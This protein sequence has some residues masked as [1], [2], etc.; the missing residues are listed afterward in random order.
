H[1]LIIDVVSWRIIVQDLQ[2]LLTPKALTGQLLD[3]KTSSYRQWVDTVKN[4][5]SNHQQEVVYWQNVMATQVS[6]PPVGKLS[7]QLVALSIKVTD[8]LLRQSNLGYHTQINDLLLS[9][10][11]VALKATFAQ[12]DNLI[13]LEG[14]GREAIDPSIDVSHTLGWFTTTYPVLLS[15]TDSISDTIIQTKEMLNKTPEK[16]IGFGA[17]LATELPPVSFNY[18]GQLSAGKDNNDNNGDWQIITQGCGVPI[19]PDNGDALLLNINGA[20]QQGQ[21]QFGVDSRLSSDLTARFATA[22]EAALKAVIEQGQ[23]QAKMGSI[24][25]PADFAVDISIEHLR[26]LQSQYPAPNAIEALYPANSLQQ[27]FI[28]HYLS[29]PKDDAYRVQMLIDYN[30]A[31]DVGL[32]QQAWSL[33]SLRYPAL[34][35]AFDWQ[36]Q[37]LQVF[38]TQSSISDDNFSV[39]DISDLPADQRDGAIEQIQGQDRARDF[40]LSQPGLIRFTLIKQHETLTTVLKTEHHGISDGWSWPVLMQCVH[41]FYDALS[42]GQLPTVEPETAYLAAQAFNLDDQDRINGYWT[43]EKSRFGEANDINRM[44]SRPIDL[45]TTKTVVNP[46]EQLLCLQGDTYQQLKA[47]CKDQGV[48]LNV[49]LQFAWHKLI[50]T[51]CADEQTIVGTTVSGRDLAV[52]GIESSVGLYINTLP[53]VVDW[54]EHK[55][56]GKMLN[57]IALQMASLN[58]YSNVSLASLQSKGERLFHSLLVFENYPNP[59]AENGANH[60]IADDITLRYSVEKADYPLTLTAYEQGECLYMKINYGQD[61][62]DDLQ[63]TRLLNQLQLILI[64]ISENPEQPHDQVSMLGEDERRALL[65]DANQTAADYPQTTLHQ[66]FELQV[67]KTPDNVALIFEQ[68]QLTYRQLDEKANQLARAIRAAYLLYKGETLK[69]DALIALYLDRSIEMVVSILAVLKAGGAYVP[70]L[71]DTPLMRV[72]YILGDTQTSL[73]LTQSKHV[74][75]LQQCITAADHPPVLLTVDCPDLTKGIAKSAIEGISQPDDLAYVIYTSGT[76]GQPKGVMVP[77]RGV[78]NRIHWMQKQYPQGHND[79]ILQKTPYSFDVSVWE[80]LWANWV[81]ATIVMAPPEVHKDPQ[82]LDQLLRQSRTTTVHFVPSMLSGYCHYLAQQQQTLPPDISRVFCSG[83]ALMIDDVNRFKQLSHNGAALINLYGPTEASIDVSYFDCTELENSTVPIGQPI[84]NTQLLVLNEKQQPVPL[85]TTGELYIG[86]VGLARGYLHQVELTSQQFIENPF[87]TQQDR[88][89]GYNRLYKTGDVVRWLADEQGRPSELQYLGRN[90]NQVKIRGFRIEL[91][92]IQSVLADL[93]QVKQ[94]VVIDVK[95]NNGHSLAAYVVMQQWQLLDTR[96]VEDALANR[97]PD[98]MVPTTF[99]QIDEVP[100]T[101][102][103]KLDRR[104]LPQPQLIANDAYVAPRSAIEQQLCDIYKAVLSLKRVGIKDNFYRIGGDSIVSIRLVSK[105]REAGFELQVKAIFDEPTVAGLAQLLSREQTAEVPIDVEQQRHYWRAVLTE[106]GK[107]PTPQALNFDT[108]ALSS[109]QTSQLLAQA[110]LGYNTQTNDLLLSALA[111]ALKQTFGTPVSH[112]MSEGQG[113]E[114][115][116]ERFDTTRYPVKL[117]VEEQLAE[118]IIHTKEMLRLIPDNG[119]DFEA[120]F[121]PDEWCQPAVSFYYLESADSPRLE[122]NTDSSL[123]NING[124]VEA[125]QLKFTVSSRLSVQQ[126]QQFVMAYDRALMAVIKHTQL[127]AIEGG[128]KTLND[129]NQLGEVTHFV[130]DAPVDAQAMFVFPPGYGGAESYLDN[131]CTA[132]PQSKLVLFNNLYDHDKLSNAISK[133]YYSFEKLAK[134][135]IKLIKKEQPHGPYHLM[136]WSF[137]G[138][139]AVEVARQLTLQGDEVERIIVI[140][141]VFNVAQVSRELGIN[142]KNIVESINYRYGL[143]VKPFK[144]NAQIILFQATKLVELDLEDLPDGVTV[145]EV[146]RLN[147]MTEYYLKTPDNLLGE[148]VKSDKTQILTMDSCH[149]SWTKNKADVDLIADSII[150]R[151]ASKQ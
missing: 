51:Y 68:S 19:S 141:S 96:A 66:L 23:Q 98:Y 81:G 86:G 24:K 71:P 105:L 37:L 108:I 1:H 50:K 49:A 146:L 13:T 106:Q 5:G 110:N 45:T 4:Y 112:V 64:G 58:S 88:D 89:K 113:S 39:V 30:R 21:L 32:Y 151:A 76:T 118:T 130:T 42:Q 121:K 60:G 107:M 75:T 2:R 142:N 129:F 149:Y 131:I 46:A 124:A 78:V 139:L 8:V 15:A 93:P 25:T 33:A 140:D 85:G 80:L 69:P 65:Y 123:L 38:S 36:A 136:G 74:L 94:A 144:T 29:Q 3:R 137:G 145:E 63:A 79:N 70:I 11:A 114:P 43:E 91:V 117:T 27:G 83:E 7:H 84:D 53:L 59:A 148:F 54:D 48:T 77:H 119:I 126:T 102:N 87:M 138:V 90:D 133:Q 122:Q 127:V 61:W 44:F 9:A 62:L 134:Q 95:N 10:L 14:H 132:L 109:D 6:Y 92:E 20:V 103:G 104:A 135:Y 41:D 116:D 47:L 34:R 101:L 35:M 143:S 115:T 40:E 67:E 12:A 73:V 111:I 82:A 97:L 28:Y 56:S 100:L 120:L 147:T 99:T 16:G 55:S 17:L 72:Q 150:Q 18:L 22:F 128:I 52:E 57:V 26:Q 31:L 125:G